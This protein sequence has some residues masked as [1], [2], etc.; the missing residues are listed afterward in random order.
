LERIRALRQEQ[1]EILQA[2]RQ[3]GEDIVAVAASFLELLSAKFE[4]AQK[5]DE[6]PEGVT[7]H[8]AS[9]AARAGVAIQREALGLSAA[10][11]GNLLAGVA[12]GASAVASRYRIRKPCQ[13][14]LQ[15]GDHH[16]GIKEQLHRG[17]ARRAREKP[18]E[19]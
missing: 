17:V 11:S 19:R 3:V 16:G 9:L 5:T 10:A 8:G 2:H 4:A 15:G 7:L 1:V 13:A 6:F 18:R 12:L 14:Q